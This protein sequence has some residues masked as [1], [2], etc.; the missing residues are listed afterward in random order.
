MSATAACSPPSS[1]ARAGRVRHGQCEAVTVD[2]AE[3]VLAGHRG[4][5]RVNGVSR[6]RACGEHVERVDETRADVDAGRHVEQTVDRLDA[7]F[8]VDELDDERHD[9]AGA[10]DGNA[11]VASFVAIVDRGFEAVM[12][13]GE[14]SGR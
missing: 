12:S 2:D 10:A 9:R 6:V 8:V 14:H 13:V 5:E 11:R 3:R 4:L 7:E 1:S